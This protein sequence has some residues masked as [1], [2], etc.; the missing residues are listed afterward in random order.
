MSGDRPAESRPLPRTLAELVR[1]ALAQIASGKLTDDRFRLPRRRGRGGSP[2]AALKA[3]AS[4]LAVAVA[5]GSLLAGCGEPAPAP[6]AATV[7]LPEPTVPASAMAMHSRT[8][9]HRPQ[10]FQGPES[11]TTWARTIPLEQAPDPPPEPTPEQAPDQPPEPTPEQ[12][13]DQPPE[14]TSEPCNHGAIVKQIPDHIAL[15]GCGEVYGSIDLTDGHW[16]IE[17]W[18]PEGWLQPALET[19][20]TGVYLR[21]SDADDWFYLG[22]AHCHSWKD[23]RVFDYT[24]P[25]QIAIGDGQHN[26]VITFHRVADSDWFD[27]GIGPIVVAPWEASRD[28]RENPCFNPVARADV[29]NPD[30]PPS[31]W[32]W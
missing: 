31:A 2:Q 15:V 1:L 12:A 27:T 28:N 10:Q 7:A 32:H 23:F 17:I 11:P 25:S 13:P 14:P 18:I 5:T 21:S 3:A 30:L 4:L 26:W 24:G 20:S 22:S 19:Q 16:W 6:R 8:L 9:A 29:I